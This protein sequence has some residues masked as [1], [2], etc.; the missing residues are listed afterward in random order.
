M[1]RKASRSPPAGCR[2]RCPSEASAHVAQA[3]E[4]SARGAGCGRAGRVRAARSRRPGVSARPASWASATTL[5]GGAVGDVDADEIAALRAASIARRPCPASRAS[6]A[7][8]TA[9]NFGASS[10]RCAS[11]WR[12]RP[13]LV[14]QEAHVAELVELVRSDR[15]L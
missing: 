15:A 9:S 8:I 7:L 5:F 2:S 10:A 12:I 6:S 13:G 11:M 14:F 1:A 4:R 3:A